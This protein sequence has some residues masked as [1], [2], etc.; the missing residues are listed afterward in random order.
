MKKLRFKVNPESPNTVEVYDESCGCFLTRFED[1]I[2]IGWHGLE[3]SHTVLLD[4]PQK[5]VT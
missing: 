5:E 2:S 4:E 1:V 3:D